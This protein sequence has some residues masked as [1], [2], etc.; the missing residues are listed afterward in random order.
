MEENNLKLGLALGGGSALG[1]AHI[2]VLKALEEN[3][4]S[5][6]FISG[7]SA[8][9]VIGALYAFGISFKDI[10]Q[11]A[12]QLDWIKLTKLHPSSL[13]ITSNVAVREILERNIGKDADITDAKIPLAIIATDI[14]TGAKIVF[15]SGNVVDA[16][17]ASSCLPGLFAP[18]KMHG[19]MLV[20]GGIVE[21]VPI[22]PL[23]GSNSDIV[24]A[25]NLLRYRKYQEPKNITGVL[26]NSFDMINHRISIQPKENDI[27]V[28]IE[29]NL[30]DYFMG[31]I[32]KWKEIS[33][34]GYSET[35]KYI[36]KIKK[37]QKQSMQEDFWQK[38]KRLLIKNKIIEKK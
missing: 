31:D 10:E 13:G 11:E 17:L 8:G 20:D 14:E 25:V 38:L 5:V 30:S 1:F 27:D 21:N 23:K 15:K 18:V 37:L 3:N 32:K 33:A 12:E 24:V 7:T 2:G 29:P 36:N 34:Q 6:D 4:I 22:S 35:L 26:A 9:A 28:L 16:V 19:L